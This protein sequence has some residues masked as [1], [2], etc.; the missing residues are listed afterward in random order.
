MRQLENI[1]QKEMTRKEFLGT[2]GFGVASIFGLTSILRFVFG[3]GTTHNSN[4]SFGYGS[5][6]YGGRK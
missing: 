3:K 2:L 1:M 6:I 5:N 4:A